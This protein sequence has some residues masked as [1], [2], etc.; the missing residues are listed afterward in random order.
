MDFFENTV[1][2]IREYMANDSYSFGIIDI[3]TI[4]R[5]QKQK[6]NCPIFDHEY[7]HKCGVTKDDALY[8]KYFPLSSGK[9][10]KV[11]YQPWPI[12]SHDND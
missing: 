2:K 8:F 11:E 12:S 9:Y 1:N 7:I 3:V 5:G 6:S 10:V 4:P